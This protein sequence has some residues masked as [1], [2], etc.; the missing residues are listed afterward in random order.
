MKHQL[1]PESTDG[2]GKLHQIEKGAELSVLLN[3]ELTNIMLK[4]HD[5]MKS[6]SKLP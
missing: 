3:K 1:S 6:I 4:I 5:I 2:L